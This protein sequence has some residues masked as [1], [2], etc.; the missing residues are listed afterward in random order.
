MQ[1]GAT[2]K[3]GPTQESELVPMT[4]NGWHRSKKK[5]DRLLGTTQWQS[6]IR[7]Y[8]R[9]QRQPC[10]NGHPI[11][12]DS[13]SRNPD[14][15]YRPDSLTVDH[16]T[17]RSVARSLGWTEAQINSISNTQPMCRACSNRQGSKLGRQ[18]QAAAMATPPTSDQ[19][20]YSGREDTSN[21]PRWIV[22]GYPCKDQAEIDRV[23]LAIANGELES[24]W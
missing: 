10:V 5:T 1:T 4:N 7:G 2:S 23:L 12:Y 19:S 18:R 14:G 8:W 24:R 13:P 21:H 3:E 22:S 11:D 15:T 16:K 6:W 9:Q 17:P 20:L